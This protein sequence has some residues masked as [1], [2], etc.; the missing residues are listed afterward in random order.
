[1]QSLKFKNL[2]FLLILI[3]WFWFVVA[4]NPRLVWN[5]NSDA[6]NPII[7][8]NP[9]NSQAFY[10]Q[11]KW[12]PNFYKIISNTGFLLYLSLTV[13]AISWSDQDYWVIVRDDLWKL[14]IN[15]DATNFKWTEFYEKF[16][17]DLYYQWP[18]FERQVQSWVYYV[19][20]YSTDNVWKYA[21][22]VWK[23][24][25][26]P[27]SEIVNTFKDLPALKSYFFEKPQCAYEYIDSG[28]CLNSGD[29][30]IY[31][32]NMSIGFNPNHNW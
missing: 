15:I 29:T 5:T 7:V 26:R 3:S 21:L 12:T 28:S 14:L 11:L 1:M 13:P 31:A 8:Q 16:A 30:F 9:E 24:E 17:W 4:H 2:F 25:S 6:N 32:K 22:A 19:Q 20:V 10:A 18:W 23:L 27:V